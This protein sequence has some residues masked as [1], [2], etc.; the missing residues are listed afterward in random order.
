MQTT[1]VAHY[2]MSFHG[3]G[4]IE[5]VLRQHH[6][7]DAAQGMRSDFVISKGTEGAPLERVHYLDL[8]GSTTIR[9]TQQTLETL[10]GGDAARVAVYHGVSTPRPFICAADHAARRVVML[11]GVGSGVGPELSRRRHWLDGVICVNEQALTA[12]RKCLPHLEASRFV[13]LPLPIASCP[14]A[15]NHPPMGLRPVVVAYAGRLSREH[16]CVDRLPDLCVELEQRQATYRLEILGDGPEWLW[17]HER[18]ATNSNVRFHGRLTGE[19]YWRAL[20]ACDVILFVSDT[21][22]QPLALLEGMCAG[23]LP[24]FP[25]IGSAGDH[26]T[27]KVSPDLLYAPG[28]L[29]ELAGIIIRLGQMPEADIA[30]LR[31]RSQEAVASHVK[32]EYFSHFSAFIHH[33]LALPK[34]SE[35]R[36]GTQ[37]P[38]LDL[39]PF[40]WISALGLVRHRLR[41]KLS[42]QR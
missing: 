16:K 34:V 20:A 18:L 19:A 28:S 3:L 42:R 14:F 36:F 13:V 23:L 39:L 33:L 30:R 15:P 7:H 2:Y 25:R 41:Q 21:E 32:G 40:R 8:D 17:L 24:V 5:A 22:G 10:F 6:A 9:K 38:G 27:E 35:D 31:A 1:K 4:G 37:L 11:H 29:P 12:A 26:Y